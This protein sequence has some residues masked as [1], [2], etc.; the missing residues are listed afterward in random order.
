MHNDT[1][2][3]DN[4]NRSCPFLSQQEQNATQ[5]ATPN[6]NGKGTNLRR[7]VSDRLGECCFIEWYPLF[8]IVVMPPSN[9]NERQARKC[10]RYAGAP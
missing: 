4:E 7:N 1:H 2:K 6:R 10:R 9:G 8:A 5:C 3:G